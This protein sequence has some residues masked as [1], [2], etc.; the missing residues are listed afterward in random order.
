MQTSRAPGRTLMVRS[1]R[2]ARNAL[3]A[4][5]T[6]GRVLEKLSR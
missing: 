2:Q 6:K 3:F 4:I 5:E 1:A